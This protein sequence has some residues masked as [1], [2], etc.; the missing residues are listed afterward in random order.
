VS[1]DDHNDQT[2]EDSADTRNNGAIALAPRV[3]EGEIVD[4]EVAGAIRVLALKNPFTPGRVES[5]VPEGSTLLDIVTGLELEDWKGALVAIDGL[6]VEQK[7]WASVRPKAEHLVT[8]RA[9]PRGGGG[10][11]DKGWIQLAAAV[12]LIVVGI[13]LWATPFGVPLII[14]GIGMAIS[15]ALT[16]LLPP[17]TLPK[18]KSGSATDQPVYSITGSRNVANPWGAP[19]SKIGR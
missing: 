18:L 11:G 4:R 3:L 13:I 17:P 9:I 16:L 6:P 14:L 12:V 2:D 8:V 15:G 7:W 19:P 1:D 5:H 10:S